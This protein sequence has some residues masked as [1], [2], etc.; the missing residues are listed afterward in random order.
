M[1]GMSRPAHVRLAISD[2]DLSDFALANGSFTPSTYEVISYA[3]GDRKLIPSA[4]YLQPPAL[5][6]QSET[7]STVGIGVRKNVLSN[8][9]PPPSQY[10]PRRILEKEL[11]DLLL[12]DRRPVITLGG[13]GGIG[14]TFLALTV[15]DQI[16]DQDRFDNIW[17]FSSR[18]IDLLPVGPKQVQPDVVNA[19]DI[20][21]TFASLTSQEGPSTKAQPLA[22]AMANLLR[23]LSG[24]A[25][26]GASLFVFDN[27]E[28]VDAPAD[29]YRWLED[30]IRL[31]NK[32]LITTRVRSFKGDWPVDVSGMTEEEFAE[33][34][35]TVSRQLGI[36]GHVTDRYRDELFAESDGHPYIARIFLGEVARTGRPA[37]VERITGSHEEILIALFERTFA[38]SLSPAAQRVFLT[39]CGWRSLV[40]E[41]ALQ[42]ALL[43]PGNERID[44]V[45][46]VDELV[47]SSLVEATEGPDGDRFLSVPL[48]A[49]LFGRS[50]LRVAAA[51]PAIESDLTIL[52]AFGAAQESDIQRGLQPR[53]E[54]ALRAAEDRT[55]D[56]LPILEYVAS[57]YAPAWLN[58][59]DLRGSRGER[60]AEAEAL[61]QYASLKPGDPTGWRRLAAAE[62]ALGDAEAEMNALL[63]LAELPTTPY[64]EI[65]KAA[66]TFNHHHANHRLS[67][68][69]LEKR[70]VAERL[71]S[72]MDSRI[73]EA[74]ATDFSRL[75]WICM[76]L[77]DQI[78]AKEYARR[79]LAIDPGNPFCRKLL[80][81]R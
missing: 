40:A 23:W 66:D 60:R 41:L 25:N 47:R 79:G 62:A 2:V 17:W 76:H 37:S 20:A 1:L 38:I 80:E 35:A 59:A 64:R 74:D 75:G 3:S 33:L 36:E 54:A 44:V 50:R 13:R 42:A 56:L 26:A 16:A 6:P 51:K 63:Q 48:A 78:S 24:G 70:L 39:L 31:P 12:D 57:H 9:P 28:T 81:A 14:K 8:M 71:R 11:R 21:R 61:A 15:L 22:A 4:P 52:R 27:F 65:S 72:L 68:D 18:D 10:V 29:V 34:V 73:A 5:L 32:I 30:S 55:D 45:G 67:T 58:I 46:A 7:A 77:M 19:D 49:Q 53:I 43:R 69:S